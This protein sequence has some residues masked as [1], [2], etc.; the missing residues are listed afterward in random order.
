MTPAEGGESGDLHFFVPSDGGGSTLVVIDADSATLDL[1]AG[2]AWRASVQGYVYTSVKRN[3]KRHTLYLHRLLLGLDWMDPREG[4]HRNYRRSDNR[5][6]N[7]EVVSKI[8]NLKSRRSNAALRLEK[9]I[10][11]HRPLEGFS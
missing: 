2:K 9:W 1:V 8:E 11:I 10:A 4:N 6:C 3:G 7:L 5:R